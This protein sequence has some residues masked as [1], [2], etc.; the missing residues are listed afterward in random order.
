MTQVGGLDRAPAAAR[1]HALWNRL[2]A[3]ERS[4]VLGS[5]KPRL[6]RRRPPGF[7]ACG[8]LR[9]LLFGRPGRPDVV[10]AGRVPRGLRF[11]VDEHPP[12]PFPGFAALRGTTPAQ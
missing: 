12:R 3:P 4:S 7:R 6:L 1:D 2:P 9:A 8:P 10:C 5:R 11:V